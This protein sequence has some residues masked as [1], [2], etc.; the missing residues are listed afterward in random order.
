[1]AYVEEEEVW[2]CPK[3]PSR[4]RKSGVCPTCLRDRLVILCPDCANLRPCACCAPNTTSSSSSSL[5]SFSSS[6]R[7]F[8]VSNL[9]DGEP[10]FRRSRSLAV[11][12]LRSRFASER[13]SGVVGG[14]G[15]GGERSSSL[16]SSVFKSQKAK[17]RGGGREEEEAKRTE[18]EGMSMGMRTMRSR[19]VG[20]STAAAARSKRREWSF[21]SPMKIF[22]QS[23]SSKAVQRR[24]PLYK[25]C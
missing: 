18:E 8:S 3:H 14:G 5:S 25:G 20:V 11:P 4:R 12:F 2:K 7:S 13:G 6:S 24:S 10:S 16:W 1:M 23:N 19:S 21:P 17:K 9:I 15:G 22:R